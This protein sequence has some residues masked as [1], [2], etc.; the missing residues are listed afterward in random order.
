MDPEYL[1]RPRG[2]SAKS[3]AYFMVCIGPASSIFDM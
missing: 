2:W 3:I 1:A